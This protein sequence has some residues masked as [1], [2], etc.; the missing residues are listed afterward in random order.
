MYL[1]SIG[2]TE[3]VPQVNT[4]LITIIVLVIITIVLIIILTIDQVE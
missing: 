2:Q 4:V 1:G 3:T